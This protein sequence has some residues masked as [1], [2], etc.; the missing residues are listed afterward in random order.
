MSRTKLKNELITVTIESYVFE[1]K[2]LA[3]H[4]NI[5]AEGEEKDLVIFVDHAY[6]GDTAVVEIRKKKKNYYEA[7]IRELITPSPYRQTARCS[8]FGVCGGCR[9]QDMI[10]SQQVKFKHEQVVNLFERQGGFSGFEI[11]DIVPAPSEFYYRNKMEFTFARK[12]WLTRDEIQGDAQFDEALFA[13][14]H[15]PGVYDKVIDINECFLQSPESNAILNYSRDFF[16]KKGIP[17]YTTSDHTGFL[18]NLVIRQTGNTD[19]LMVNLVTAGE[20]PELMQEYSVYI[21]E[22]VPGITTIVNNINRGKATVATGEYEIVI[23]GPG[24]IEDE[25]GHCRFRISSNSFFQT[26]TKQAERLYAIAREFAGIKKSDVVYDL[27]CGAGTI[28]LYVAGDA[29]E[30]Y[31]FEASSSAIKDAAV[32]QQINRNSNTRFFESNLYKSFLPEVEGN[33]LPKPDILITDPPRNGMHTTT[34]EDIL[35][36]KPGKIVYISCNPATQVRDIKLLA[37]GGYKLKKIQPVDMFPHTYHIENVALLK[38]EG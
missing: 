20:N 5:T 16:L 17:A 8:Y 11:L 23:Y 15:V 2:G 21:R 29:K 14:L 7:V 35:K 26:N 31:G 22:L 10:Y 33:A 28:S 4:R 25:I 27:Y 3:R 19:Q 38:D 32:N 18:R 12:R 34:V 24:Y 9:Q 36:L 30:V 1:G 13:G 6:P 37:E